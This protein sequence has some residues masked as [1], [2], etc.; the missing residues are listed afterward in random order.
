[1]CL[2]WTLNLNVWM[3]EASSVTI[4]SRHSY[5]YRV[6]PVICYTG[7]PSHNAY[8]QNERWLFFEDWKLHLFL[9]E[10]SLNWW[11]WTS[12]TDSVELRAKRWATQGHSCGLQLQVWQRLSYLKG[13]VCKISEEAW[14]LGKPAWKRVS[15]FGH[16]QGGFLWKW[17]WR[18]QLTRSE[19]LVQSLKS[20]P[21]SFFKH[22]ATVWMV[23]VVTFLDAS[24][25]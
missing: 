7:S 9:A 5:F 14:Y 18:T 2:D 6:N 11:C 15:Y 3:F 22:I 4:W 23:P 24:V 19:T 17:Q 1:M 21:T 8:C 25:T 12:R 20:K 13:P 16:C 10:P